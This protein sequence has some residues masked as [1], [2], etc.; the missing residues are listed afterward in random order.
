MSINL[1]PPTRELLPPEILVSIS[2]HI[3]ESDRENA[4]LTFVAPI[5]DGRGHG[6]RFINLATGEIKMANAMTRTILAY[7]KRGDRIIDRATTFGPML[8]DGRFLVCVV[9]PGVMVFRFDPKVTMHNEDVG[10]QQARERHLSERLKQVRE[11]EER[12]KAS[13]PG[14]SA[15][16]H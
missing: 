1:S 12:W 11:K 8:G 9:G 15:V 2:D 10:F 7:K 13:S 14:G 5:L 4:R 16:Q 6:V 3:L